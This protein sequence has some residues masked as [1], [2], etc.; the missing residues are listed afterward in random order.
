M[1][2]LIMQKNIDAF[3]EKFNI[4]DNHFKNL[5]IN[6]DD[7]QIIEGKIVIATREPPIFKNTADDFLFFSHLIEKVLLYV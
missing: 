6:S 2:L 4:T 1:M 5:I 3:L 7:I